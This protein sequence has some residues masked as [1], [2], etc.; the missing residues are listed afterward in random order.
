MCEPC[1]SSRLGEA[2]RTVQNTVLSVKVP[3]SD[4]LT[5]REALQRMLRGRMLVTYLLDAPCP[6]HIR[7]GESAR[8][9]LGL[10]RVGVRVRVRE[11]LWSRVRVRVTMC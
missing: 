1:V 6:G 3:P 2:A 5:E 10:A 9:G 7:L 8:L 11:F 4:V